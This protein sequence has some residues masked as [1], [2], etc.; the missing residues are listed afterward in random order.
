[1]VEPTVKVF[2]WKS[3]PRSNKVLHFTYIYIY[4]HTEEH[5]NRAGNR[6]IIKEEL[7]DSRAHVSVQL[8]CAVVLEEGGLTHS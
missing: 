5:V 6:V 1:M 8:S 2:I 7:T 3:I 4:I